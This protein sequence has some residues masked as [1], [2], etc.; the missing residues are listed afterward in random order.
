M[1]SIFEESL[2]SKMGSVPWVR[3]GTAG[4][5][6]FNKLCQGRS[7]AWD[8]RKMWPAR[9]LGKEKLAFLW[10]LAENGYEMD[11]EEIEKLAA[12]IKAYELEEIELEREGTRVRLCRR[13]F[14][15]PA[16][17]AHVGMPPMMGFSP[18]N[19]VNPAPPPQEPEAQILTIASPMVGTFYRAPAP[20][21][22]AFVEIGSTIQANTVVCII[23]A[24]K[25]L[26]E[27]PA[28]VGGTVVDVLVKDGQAV[29]YGQSLFKI[30]PN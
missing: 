27:I 16:I 12:L 30:R 1:F 25:V 17:P 3:Q 14:Q 24:M 22:P 20:G 9:P 13:K 10:V 11:N 2:A 5:P 6:N 7:L 28:E 15:E 29:E 8:D 21:R 19:M 18:Q 4:V 26:N 23:E